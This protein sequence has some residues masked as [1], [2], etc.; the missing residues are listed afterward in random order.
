MLGKLLLYRHLLKD[1]ILK[2]LIT[3]FTHYFCGVEKTSA[4]CY[5]KNIDINLVLLNVIS[6]MMMVLVVQPPM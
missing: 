6:G 1:C 2:I 5:V 3:S 4:N